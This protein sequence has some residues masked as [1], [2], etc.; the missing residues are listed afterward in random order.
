MLF[1]TPPCFV[2]LSKPG[3]SSALWELRDSVVLLSDSSGF[4]FFRCLG[5]IE[6]QPESDEAFPC[7]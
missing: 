1:P 6:I 5:P 4:F 3:I 7:E 2:C